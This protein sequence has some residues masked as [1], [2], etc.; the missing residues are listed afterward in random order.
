MNY[1]YHGSGD[2]T[3]GF[4]ETLDTIVVLDDEF[5]D[6]ITET[7]VIT[8]I[9]FDSDDTYYYVKFA[10]GVYLAECTNDTIIKMKNEETEFATDK[11]SLQVGQT[12]SVLCKR[13]SDDMLPVWLHGYNGAKI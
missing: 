11:S 6:A 1:T 10:D 13:E 4:Y 7:G 9:E 12:I 5:T 8:N 3:V 2:G